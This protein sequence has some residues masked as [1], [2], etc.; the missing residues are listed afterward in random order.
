MLKY[1]S[2]LLWL[3]RPNSVGSCLAVFSYCLFRSDGSLAA[4]TTL[5]ASAV[6]KQNNHPTCKWQGGRKSFSSQGFS[7]SQGESFFFPRQRHP[8][9]CQGLLGVSEFLKF[10]F[11]LFNLIFILFIFSFLFTTYAIQQRNR[12]R[13]FK[14][15]FMKGNKLNEIL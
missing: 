10:V 3:R 4:G 8:T 9:S 11:I 15:L 1:V 2:P 13:F 5:H 6:S 12:N 7:L 14:Y